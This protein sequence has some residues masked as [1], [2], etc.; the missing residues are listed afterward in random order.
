MSVA[1]SEG[2]CH[3]DT[4]RPRRVSVAAA[5]RDGGRCP[6]RKSWTASLMTAYLEVWKP[7]GR[8]IVLLENGE[9]DDE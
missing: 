1:V 9:A 6:R 5:I 4:V 7:S 8:E 3:G 2:A